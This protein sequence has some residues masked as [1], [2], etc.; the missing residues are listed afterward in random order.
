MKRS[1]IVWSFFLA[2]LLSGCSWKESGLR[3]RVDGESRYFES[4]SSWARHTTKTFSYSEN[5]KIVT[6]TASFTTIVLANY[7]LDKSRGSVSINDQVL[8]KPDQIKVRLSFTGEKGTSGSTPIVI[9]R[10]EI[11]EKRFSQITEI[12]LSHVANGNERIAELPVSGL[13]GYVEI[14]SVENNRIKGFI[15]IRNSEE[16]IRGEFTAEGNSSVK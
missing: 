11:G 1:I 15:D 13:Q 14:E 12:S 4:S 10:Y 8:S 3:V 9:G 2:L 5:G 7:S 6:E 16:I